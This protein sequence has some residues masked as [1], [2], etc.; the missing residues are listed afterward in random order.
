MVHFRAQC[1]KFHGSYDNAVAFKKILQNDLWSFI[2][3]PIRANLR[4]RHRRPPIL[5]YKNE[6]SYLSYIILR[7][8]HEQ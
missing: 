5:V 3:C 6:R 2:F 8:P 7:A 1:P 4:R